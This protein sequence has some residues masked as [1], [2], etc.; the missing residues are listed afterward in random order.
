MSKEF[1]RQFMK[2]IVSNDHRKVLTLINNISVGLLDRK[3]FKSLTIHSSGEETHLGKTYL[4][5]KR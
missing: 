4:K 1:D 3:E 2:K 5:D